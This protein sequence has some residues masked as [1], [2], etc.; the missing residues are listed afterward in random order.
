MA[1]YKKEN[2][3]KSNT[4][5]ELFSDKFEYNG[6]TENTVLVKDFFSGLLLGISIGEMLVGIYV[7][8]K[9]IAVR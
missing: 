3:F 9:G 7:V 5:K 6:K 1:R 8:G 4:I 2:V